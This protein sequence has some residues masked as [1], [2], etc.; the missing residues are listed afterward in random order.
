MLAN[1]NHIQRQ[2]D[3]SAITYDRVA[4]MQRLIADEL[5]ALLDRTA[6]SVV[7][8]G[9]GTGYALSKMKRSGITT[10]TG[11]D[12]APGMLEHALNVLPEARLVQG[13]IE[14]LP[15]ISG[16][17]D[18]TFSSSAIQWCEL[19]SA[20]REVDRVTKP[21]GQ[22]LM[23]SFLRGTLQSWRRLWRLDEQQRFASLAMFQGELA[24]LGWA[25]LRIWTKSY[26]QRFASFDEAVSSIRDLGAG[27]MS[28]ER[29][30]GLMGRRQ[31][32]AIKSSIEAIIQQ[33]GYIELEYEVVFVSARKAAFAY[34]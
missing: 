33:R 8:L 3:H 34:G 31:F 19:S 10:I 27:N 12:L 11:L 13:D 5:L 14:S 1:K 23:S 6:E 30:P 16:E 26:P 22:V 21:G 15:F 25:N 28:S 32:T 17:F 9:C 18:V 7:D 2:F 29:K 4:S 24:F 20:L